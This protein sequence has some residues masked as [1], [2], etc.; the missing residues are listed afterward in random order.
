[1]RNARPAIARRVL[2]AAAATALAAAPAA[3]Q[4]PNVQMWSVQPFGGMFV[5]AYDVGADGSRTGGLLGLQV[6]RR[7]GPGVRGV[8]TVAYARVHDVAGRSPGVGAYHVLANEWVFAA[9][10][11]AFDATWRRATVTLS[12][13]AGAAWR[14][15]PVVGLVGRTEVDPWVALGADSYSVTSVVIPGLAVRVPLSHR[16]SLA[17]AASVYGTSLDEGGGRSRA[18]TLGLSYAP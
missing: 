2:L 4:E 1:M 5:D 8:A 10:G 3:A 17:G 13:Q 16:V 11:P 15:T 12:V 18:F 7:I 9:V 6:A 14:R